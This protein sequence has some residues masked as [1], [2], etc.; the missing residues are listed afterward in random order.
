MTS[1]F[2]QQ[3]LCSP[4]TRFLGLGLAGVAFC[5]GLLLPQSAMATPGLP[6]ITTQPISAVVKVGQPRS[7]SVTNSGTGPFGY[8]WLKDGV[9]LAGQTNSTLSYTSFAFTNSGSYSVVITNALGMAI[10]IPASLSV[11]NAALLAWGSNGYGQLGNGTNGPEVYTSLPIT[12]ASNVVAMARGGNHSLF[13]KADNTL[14]AMGYNASGGLGNGTTMDTSLPV[15]VTNNVVAVAA[16]WLHSLFV[17]TDGTLW[18]MGYNFAGQ[19]GNGNSGGNASTNRPI[20]VTS[21]VVAIAAGGEYSLFVKADGTLWAMGYNNYGQFGNGITGGITNWPIMVASNVMAVTASSYHSLFVKTDGTLW[22]MGNNTDGQ[23]GNGMDG[24]SAS[25]N[26]PIQVTDNVVAMAAGNQHS[27]FVKADGTLWAMGNNGYGQLG[28]GTLTQTNRPIVVA[29]NVVTVASG[30]SH[31]MFVKADGTLWA[32]GNNGTGQLGDGTTTL[33]TVPVLVN[34]GSLLAVSLAKGSEADH[35]W[36]IGEILLPG[37]QVLGIK[38]T[39]FAPILPVATF[40]NTFSITNNGMPLLPVLYENLV[41][42]VA[43]F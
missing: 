16:G 6:V 24:M 37:L 22:A 12:V 29:S 3:T 17:K 35:S 20:Q 1:S 39:R 18:A 21:N 30:F 25:T 41:G 26:L 27:M 33:S 9:I 8:Q 31:S 43:L 19:L 2:K 40:T 10:S 38:G 36:A 42:S 34:G 4:Y 32:T 11:T 7:L 15:Q 13:V 28:A 23:L 14:W 5:L